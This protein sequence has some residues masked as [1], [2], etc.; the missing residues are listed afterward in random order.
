MTGDA[1]N[2]GWE[3]LQGTLGGHGQRGLPGFKGSRGKE[4]PPGPPGGEGHQGTIGERGV[5]GK[6]GPHGPPGLPGLH[7]RHAFFPPIVDCIWAHWEAW[8]ECTASCGKG[9]IQRR[10]RSVHVHPQGGGAN[11]DGSH[12]ELRFCRAVECAT[13]I[14]PYLHDQQ[15]DPLPSLPAPGPAPKEVMSSLAEENE[16]DALEGG[17]A[18]EASPTPKNAASRR[19][20]VARSSLFAALVASVAAAM[21]E[22]IIGAADAVGS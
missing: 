13:T 10:E 19:C 8:E 14:A 18:T 4:G 6:T 3:G 12:F 1:G 21:A 22:Q 11:C 2:S 9:G 17:D 16:P 7:G 5:V 20:S 15:F